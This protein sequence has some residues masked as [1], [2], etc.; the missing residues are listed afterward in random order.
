LPLGVDEVVDVLLGRRVWL[1]IGAVDR[2]GIVGRHCC[3]HQPGSHD[4]ACGHCEGYCGRPGAT[5]SGATGRGDRLDDHAGFVGAPA[6][7]D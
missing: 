5:A 6:E 7:L 2:W 1:G 4:T 3:G